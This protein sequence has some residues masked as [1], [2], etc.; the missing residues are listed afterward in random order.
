LKGRWILAVV[1]PV[2]CT[3]AFWSLLP[4]A[5]RTSDSTDY[6]AFYRPEAT[7]IATGHG[8]TMP[9]GT[10]A[11]RVPPGYPLLLAGVLSA[12]QVV[13]LH[14]ERALEVLTLLCV[15]LSS[16]FLF[17]LSRTCWEGPLAL[18]PSLAWSVYPLTLWL[19]RQPSSEVPFTTVLLAGAYVT[20]ELAGS[21]RP[22]VTMIALAGFLAGAAMLVRPIAMLLPVVFALTPWIVRSAW[23]R[24]VR[25]LVG[26]GLIA[27]SLATVLPWE[28]HASNEADHFVL[29][30]AAGPSSIRDGLTFGVNADKSYRHGIYVP[31]AVRVVMSNFYSQYGQLDSYGS[32]LR[33]SSVQLREHPLGTVGLIAYKLLR[34]GYGTDS[35]QFDSALLVVQGILFLCLLWLS[36]VAWRMG[37]PP[38]QLLK[39]LISV[40]GYFWIMSSLALP[41]VRYIVPAL[42]LAFLLVPAAVRRPSPSAPQIPR[43]QDSRA[44]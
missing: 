44:G 40:I 23:P 8:L 26:V 11:L 39:F 32:I 21:A 6:A 29:L 22:R 37:P 42:G 19:S 27:A 12:G 30:S 38:R 10:P 15:G 16:L 20:W 31:A 1:V 41:L 5:Y 28:V 13:G 35:Q 2:A 25:V 14:E 7:R 17:L 9:D 3:A 34:V 36:L 18:L 4:A 24:R 33:A 43:P